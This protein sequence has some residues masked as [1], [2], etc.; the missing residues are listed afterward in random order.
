MTVEPPAA[1][2]HQRICP[3][4]GADAAGAVWCPACGLNLR[5]RGP[6][7]AAGSRDPARPRAPMATAPPAPPP[8]DQ[9]GKRPNRAVLIAVGALAAV[10]I[11]LLVIVLAGRHEKTGG[12]SGE[13]AI[14]GSTTTTT[15][16]ATATT[17]QAAALVTAGAMRQVLSEYVSAYSAEDLQR[18]RALFSSDLVRQNGTDPAQNLAGALDTY[19]TQFA[20]LSNPRYQLSNLRYSQGR[21]VGAALGTYRITSASGVNTGAIEFWFAVRDGELLITRMAIRPVS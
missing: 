1:E 12:G 7:P 3:R 19:A 5:V 8:W 10:A 15:A 11:V 17:G 18:L 9:G 14:G 21:Q 16:T 20:Q 4:C 2:E 13:A 6:A